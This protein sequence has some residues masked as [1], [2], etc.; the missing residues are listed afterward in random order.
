[1]ATSLMNDSRYVNKIMMRL[2]SMAEGLLA[3]SEKADVGMPELSLTPRRSNR[4]SIISMTE[5][6]LKSKEKRRNEKQ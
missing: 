6:Q 2:L 5:H 3:A 1:M 4:W